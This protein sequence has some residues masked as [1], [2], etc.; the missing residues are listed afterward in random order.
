MA[1][2][3]LMGCVSPLEVVVPLKID[4]VLLVLEVVAPWLVLEGL[5]L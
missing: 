1:M 3:I 4:K 5:A 2:F